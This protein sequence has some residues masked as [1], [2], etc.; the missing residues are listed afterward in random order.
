MTQLDACPGKLDVDRFYD[1][2]YLICLD[3]FFSLSCLIWVESWI[4]HCYKLSRTGR[5]VG[6]ILPLA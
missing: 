2:K 1:I 5:L 4:F 6:S 3:E